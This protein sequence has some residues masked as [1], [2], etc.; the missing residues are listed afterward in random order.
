MS[1]HCLPYAKN[2]GLQTSDFVHNSIY[3]SQN[4][5]IIVG[6]NGGY[7]DINPNIKYNKNI[8]KVIFTELK[9]LDTTINVDSLYNHHKILSQ[10]IELTD[11]ITL[12]YNQNTFKLSFSTMEYVRTHDILRSIS[13]RSAMFFA[14]MTMQGTAIQFNR[15]IKKVF[16]QPKTDGMRLLMML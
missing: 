6:G 9:V 16:L 7:Y 14:G 4:G 8:S 2:D 10:N 15:R 11:K 1:F 13:F 5:H 12:K 3:K